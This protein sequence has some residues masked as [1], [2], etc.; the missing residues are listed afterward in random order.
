MQTGYLTDLNRYTLEQVLTTPYGLLGRLDSAC[1]S[2]ASD[3]C[4]HTYTR[5]D[6]V[7]NKI[8]IYYV[9]K[10]DIDIYFTRL[11]NGTFSAVI[12]LH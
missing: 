4:S 12:P 8:Q 9:V 11:T 6:K 5:M 1:V 2:E 3:L 10:S 7:K